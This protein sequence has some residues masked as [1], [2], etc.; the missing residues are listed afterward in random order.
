MSFQF[1]VISLFSGCGGSS[2]GYRLVGGKILLAVEWDENAVQTYKLNFPDTEIYHG[3][4]KKLSVDEILEK[5]K[6]KVGELDILD[7]S[8]P[9]QGFSTAGKRKLDD[10]RNYLFKEYIR[11]LRGLKPKVF[12]MENVSGLVKGKMKLIFAEMLKEMKAS[13]YKVKCKL[14]NAMY[15]GVPQSRQRTIFIGTRE[16]L[17][18]EPSHPKP[19][20]TIH[21]FKSYDDG[22]RLS[23]D[24]LK[25]WYLIPP[26]GNWKSLP[27]TLINGKAKYSNF[28]RKLHPDKPSYTLGREEHFSSGRFYHWEQP[29]RISDVEVKRIGSYPDD[30]VFL[31]NGKQLHALVGN[32]VPPMFMKAIAEH[33]KNNILTKIE[34][35]GNQ[36]GS[37]LKI[38]S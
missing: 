6:L 24:D 3:D 13:G 29:R 4:I 10:S 30:F 35:L 16:D 7:G 25:R 31:N 22:N 27:K 23:G 15:Y 12:V 37:T 26:G 9:C 19:Q 1:K 32:S 36:N 21:T 14:M 18:I 38:N 5:T 11:I 33:I 17:G 20:T 28:H 2:L 34:L 8:P